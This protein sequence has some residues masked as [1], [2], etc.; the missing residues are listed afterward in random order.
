MLP[1]KT[2][3]TSHATELHIKCFVFMFLKL[4]FFWEVACFD[5][6]NTNVF[7]IEILKTMFLLKEFSIHNHPLNLIVKHGIML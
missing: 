1:A 2:F 4:D 3:L 7:Q 5:I 6:F